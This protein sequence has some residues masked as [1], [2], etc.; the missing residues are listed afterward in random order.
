MQFYIFVA[1]VVDIGGKFA[2]DINDTCGT[3]GKFTAGVVDTSDKFANSVV[4]TGGAAWLAN[5]N[6]PNVIFGSLGEDDSWK[7]LMLNI[8]SHC[9]FNFP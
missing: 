8:L 9:P 5:I 2:T 4:D 6:G 1:G 3:R 7:N